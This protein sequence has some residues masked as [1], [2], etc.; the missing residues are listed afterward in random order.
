MSKTKK[1][2]IAGVGTESSVTIEVMENSD[3]KAIFF[4][5]MIEY[6]RKM[7]KILYEKIFSQ[8]IM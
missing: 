7:F 2:K 1:T 6:G 8:S 3:K 4:D 5:M